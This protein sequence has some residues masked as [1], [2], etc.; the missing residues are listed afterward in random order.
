M[1]IEINHAEGV[2]RSQALEQHVRERLGRLERR[3]A[4]RVTR[5]RVFLKDVNADKGGVDKVCTMEA[6]PAGHDPIAV[7]AQDDDLYRAVRAAEGKL[8][9]ALEHRLARS[10]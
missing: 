3:Y 10:G 2:Q 4:D 7:E 1:E 5:I 9:K 6:R 8:E